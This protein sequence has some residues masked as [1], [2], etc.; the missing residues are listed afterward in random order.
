MVSS[1]FLLKKPALE[2]RIGTILDS[3][4]RM[5]T[6][7]YIWSTRSNDELDAHFLPPPVQT[8]AGQ[9][10]WFWRRAPCVAAKARLP[11]LARSVRDGRLSYADYNLEDHE[12]VGGPG[13]IP[14]PPW[15]LTV[16]VARHDASIS[17]FLRIK[18]ALSRFF[19][20]L[21]KMVSQFVV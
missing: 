12:V 4:L 2:D 1:Y 7:D 6:D 19:A 17:L 10:R 20:Y 8:P 9:D 16:E 18:N 3:S 11:D 14:H 15:F 13:T 21:R 5:T